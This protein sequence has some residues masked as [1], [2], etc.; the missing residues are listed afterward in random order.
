MSVDRF[1][2]AKR[3]QHALRS[4]YGPILLLVL[5]PANWFMVSVRPSSY[6]CTREV[7]K[8]ERSRGTNSLIAL[9]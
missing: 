4:P 5:L 9:T 6:G 8:H 1:C 2:P 3:S 7:A